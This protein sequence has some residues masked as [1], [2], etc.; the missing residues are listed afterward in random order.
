MCKLVGDRYV[1]TNC[2]HA[3][4][5]TEKLDFMDPQKSEIQENW[6]SINND[7]TAVINDRRWT[8]TFYGCF[9]S[10]WFQDQEQ[11][12][13][14]CK[15]WFGDAERIFQQTTAG[16]LGCRVLPQFTTG[17]AFQVILIYPH[18]TLVQFDHQT[19]IRKPTEP[20]RETF[21][22]KLFSCVLFQS[23]GIAIFLWLLPLYQIPRQFLSVMYKTVRYNLSGKFK[24]NH[25]SCKATKRHLHRHNTSIVL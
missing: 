12:V 5:F 25:E 16:T 23:A 17:G 14:H 22:F 4:N 15:I 13:W 3:S 1:N 7:K 21:Y 20:W 11:I 24:Q 9:V 8:L 19:V 10:K 6:C 18:H 2:C